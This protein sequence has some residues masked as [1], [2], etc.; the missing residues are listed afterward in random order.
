LHSPAFEQYDY[1]LT[2]YNG[3]IAQTQVEIRSL[4]LKLSDSRQASH[5][6]KA[7]HHTVE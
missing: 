7:F 5:K 2:T 1:K 4:S 3:Q 6:H